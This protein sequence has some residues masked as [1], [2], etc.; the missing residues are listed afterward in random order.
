MKIDF[1][2]VENIEIED[3]DGRDA[4]DFCDAFI[5][6]ATYMG[7]DATEDELDAINDNSDFVYE[8]VIEHIY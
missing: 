5:S 8:S 2:K 6:S 4:P 1:S 3:I 7:R